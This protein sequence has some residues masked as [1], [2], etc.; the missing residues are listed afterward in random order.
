MRGPSFKNAGYIDKAQPLKPEYSE[1]NFAVPARRNLAS[2][3]TGRIPAELQ[4]GFLSEMLESYIEY[5]P[6]AL[7]LEHNLSGDLK[8][9]NT[10]KRDELGMVDLSGFE[11]EPTKHQKEDIRQI[12]IF[13]IDSLISYLERCMSIGTDMTALSSAYRQDMLNKLWGILNI[14]AE[15]MRSLRIFLG[16]KVY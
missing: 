13:E 11:Q 6:D 16:K 2:K 14:L 4:P 12:Q 9:V 8:K 10:S 15:N 3:D 5:N 7:K 1:I